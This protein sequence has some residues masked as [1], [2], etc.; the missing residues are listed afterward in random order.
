[1]GF[2]HLID[3]KLKAWDNVI[4]FLVSVGLLVSQIIILTNHGGADSLVSGLAS[5]SLGVTSVL[6][7]YHLA[8]AIQHY[9]VP[10]SK[11]SAAGQHLR[12]LLTALAVV[13]V[14]TNYGKM[15]QLG[16]ATDDINRLLTLISGLALLA[17]RILDQLLDHEDISG[18]VTVKCPGPDE[19]TIPET[20]FNARILITHV[21]LL[22]SATLGWVHFGLKS[23]KHS[24]YS[25]DDEL[26]LLLA[27]IVVTTHLGLYPLVWLLKA[28]RADWAIVYCLAGAKESECNDTTLESLNRVPIIRTVVSTVALGALA[29]SVGHALGVMKAQ[30]LIASLA[31]YTSADTV[32]RNYV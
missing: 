17:M 23:T 16:V 22:G 20:V 27:N 3:N 32:G 7:I 11:E 21:L 10:N 4:H 31:F 2:L 30:L 24:T 19:P 18:T 14:G 25:T 13:S 26:L 9:C 28:L 8:L 15:L 29:I 1:M 5:A 12:N 6:A